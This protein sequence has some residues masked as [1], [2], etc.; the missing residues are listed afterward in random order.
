M[1]AK[2]IG[3]LT[4]LKSSDPMKLMND[5]A[6]YQSVLE[7]E[8]GKPVPVKKGNGGEG[9]MMDGPFGGKKPEGKA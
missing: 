9:S 8:T 4:P 3:G 5:R 1:M 2:S 6:E 7:N